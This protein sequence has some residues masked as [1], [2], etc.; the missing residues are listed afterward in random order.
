MKASRSKVSAQTA[1]KACSTF[2]AMHVSEQHDTGG[3]RLTVWQA[4]MIRDDFFRQERE[5]IQ[6]RRQRTTRLRG[7]VS[8]EALTHGWDQLRA[9][10]IAF[11]NQGT[12]GQRQSGADW[13]GTTRFGGALQEL[14]QCIWPRRIRVARTAK[15][16]YC[17][18]HGESKCW[19]A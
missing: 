1:G 10:P 11:C 8:S 16:R 9:C 4:Q 15:V 12:D 3:E 6:C 5:K 7:V 19:V 13:S 17:L 2:V 18:S 14:K